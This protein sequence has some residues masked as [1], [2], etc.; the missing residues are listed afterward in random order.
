MVSC[1]QWQSWWSSVNIQLLRKFSLY[2]RGISFLKRLF[3]LKNFGSTYWSINTSEPTSSLWWKIKC[4][5]FFPLQLSIQNGSIL[6]AAKRGNHPLSHPF[7]ASSRNNVFS[8]LFSPFCSPKCLKRLKRRSINCLEKFLY[9]SII[10]YTIH[11][12]KEGEKWV[13]NR[14]Q[15]DF[16][17]N[18]SH[19]N[20]LLHNSLA[21]K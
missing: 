6:C 2:E 10:F 21:E 15:C 13:L 12:W 17:K 7:S 9:Y 3:C 20:A 8:I 1:W 11:F 16:L 18:E 19:T 5:Q 4:T 14:C